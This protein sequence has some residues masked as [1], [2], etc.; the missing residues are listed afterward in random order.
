VDDRARGGELALV[1]LAA[2][3]FATA[4]PLAK[5]VHGV[6]FAGIGAGRCAVAAAAL[7]AWAPRETWRALRALDARRRAAIV[8]VGLLLAAHFALFLAGLLATSLAAAA[9]LV[10]LEPASVVVAVW[11]A[12]GARPRRGEIAGIAVATAGALVVSR[13]A[14]HGENTMGGDALVLGAV[15]LYGAYVASARGLREAMPVR[16]YAATVY[17]VAA[18]ALAPLAFALGAGASPPVPGV[19]HAAAASAGVP[20]SAIAAIVALGLVPTLVGHTLV[21]RA[22]RRIPASIV[23]LVA[24]GETLGSIAIGAAIGRAPTAIELAGAAVIAAG[25]TITVLSARY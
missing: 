11:A 16:A 1:G 9:A 20:S 2:A 10:S 17:G 18:V 6:S 15:V 4:S 21:Q 8:G 5:V 3:A 23:A 13:A 24:P 7:A 19:D 22:A 12:F 14:G 25:A